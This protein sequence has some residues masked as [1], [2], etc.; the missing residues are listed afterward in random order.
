MNKS[1]CAYCEQHAL[2]EL[3]KKSSGRAQLRGNQLHSAFRPAKVA[4]T[5]EAL[6]L[7]SLALPSL[8]YG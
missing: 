8:I 4:N 1:I 3:K 7:C 6:W 2:A 5:G